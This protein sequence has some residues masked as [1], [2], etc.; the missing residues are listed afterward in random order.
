MKAQPARDH[1][2]HRMPNQVGM[3]RK[4]RDGPLP[5]NGLA[6]DAQ[7]LQYCFVA[8]GIRVAQVR[9][10]PATLRNHGQEPFAGTMVFLVRL[11]MLGEQRNP[12]AQE[13]NLYFWRP[14]I[15]FV[16]LICGKNL[17]LCFNRQCHSKGNA[18]CLL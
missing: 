17:P 18:P 7:P 11:E 12:L 6:A 15:G 5:T 9:Q 13:S 8:L 16:A 3:N 1:T 10:K 2:P 14:G 4:R